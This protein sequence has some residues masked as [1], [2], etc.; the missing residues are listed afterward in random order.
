MSDQKNKLSPEKLEQLKQLQQMIAQQQKPGGGLPPGLGGA[1]K[2]PSKLTPKGMLIA[3][4]QSMQHSVK[5][6]DQFI[7]FIVKK[8]S[9][10]TNDVIKSAKAPIKFGVFVLIFFVF[11][12]LIWT[13]TAP[14]DSA[15]VVVGKV[16]SNSNKKTL[17]NPDGGIIKKI[18]VKVGQLVKKD[19]ILIELDDTRIK[20]QYENALNLY[21]SFSAA[22]SRLFAEMNN[23]NEI[24]YPPFL[25]KDKNLAEVATIINTQNDLFYSKNK[26]HIAE[27]DS[28]NQRIK[29]SKKQIEGYEAKK[30]ALQKTLEVLK[31]RVKA[32]R[33]LEKKG[34][35]KKETVQE[36]ESK[37]ANIKSDLA[38]NDT[39]IAKSEEEIIKTQIDLITHGS[40]RSTDSLTE[41]KETQIRLAEAKE[42]Y[43]VYKEVLNRIN[44]KSPVDGVVNNLNY[45]T[46]G[47]SIAPN[48]T[49]IEIS[50]SDDKLIIEAKIP[51]QNIDSVIVGLKSKI[52][53]SAF[54]SRTTP[55]FNGTLVSISPDIIVDQGQPIS[56]PKLAGG[57]YLARI[58]IDMDEFEEIAK[59]RHLKLQPGMQ[60]EV[61]IITGTRTLL[62]Y[63]MDPVIDAMFKGFKEK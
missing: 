18:N 31:E 56:D 33:I 60:A 28:A 9:D 38:V 45:H 44:I 53:F 35:A 46:V 17:N 19:E 1:Q 13:A 21:R 32:A 27:M 4:L 37:E 26:F 12:G 2:P 11:F 61:Q 30:I 49:I 57:Y 15:S 51:P 23:D 20:A 29:Q 36:F 55:S 47:S 16:I 59:P 41:L 5:F 6:V 3:I 54:K 58:E 43:F 34:F 14:L 40:K 25:I 48:S 10:Q 52:R 42:N 62:R 63:L 8:D 7:D 39:D 50:P 24:T 22:E